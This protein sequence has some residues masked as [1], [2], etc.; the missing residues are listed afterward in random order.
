[1]TMVG[2]SRCGA[3]EPRHCTEIVPT[4]RFVPRQS[5]KDLALSR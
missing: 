3:A 5:K 2:I 4:V 1:L